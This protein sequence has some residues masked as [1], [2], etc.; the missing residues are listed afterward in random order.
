M[1]R[2]IRGARGPP[3]EPL[4]AEGAYGAFDRP[5]AVGR[6][7]GGTGARV[8]RSR[9]DARTRSSL[10]GRV[11]TIAYLAA[12]RSLRVRLRRTQAARRVVA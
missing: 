8:R 11:E 3:A 6:C 7:R 10:T 5:T 12:F 1:P 4:T 2:A 9:R